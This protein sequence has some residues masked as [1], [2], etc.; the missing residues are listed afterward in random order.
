MRTCVGGKFSSSRRVIS[1]VPQG[2]VLGPLLFVLFINDLPDGINNIAKLFAD[3]LKVIANPNNRDRVDSDL[4]YLQQW[5]DT[6]LLRFNPSKCKVMHVN[7]ND[8]PLNTYVFNDVTLGTINE[9]RDLGVLSSS[10]LQWNSNIKACIAKANKMV[11]WITR[12]LILREKNVMLPIYKTI[13]R[14]HLEYCT[15]LWNPVAEH[16]NWS[17]II[18]LERVQRR[19]TSMIDDFSTLPYSERL[20]KLYLT[21]LA[22]RRIRGDL[23]ETFK[24]VNSRVDYGGNL[25]NIGRSGSNL[26][27]R[28]SKSNDPNV[29]KLVN[30]FISQRVIKYWNKLPNEVKNSESVP[31]FKINLQSYKDNCLMSDDSNY[32]E[33]SNTVISRIETP[34]YLSNRDKH[35]QYLKS[36]PDVAK[37][38]GIRM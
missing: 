38:K 18:E 2:S 30:S 34:S 35:I 29:R 20:D 21:T 23:I 10:T 31:H 37:R 16:G 8:N 9:E 4:H 26:I 17:T 19:F 25:F 3:D 12:N 22:E 36:N 33:V 24:I 14:P 27:S 28:P 32:W 13:I 5:E 11:A 1:G 7:Y 15:Q 6:W